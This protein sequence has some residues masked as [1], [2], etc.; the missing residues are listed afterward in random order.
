MTDMTFSELN[1]STSILQ[2]LD[3]MGFEAPSEIQAQCIPFLMSGRD[4]VGQAQT[5]TGKTAA[6]GIP[7]V[8]QVDPSVKEVQAVIM[9]PTR[10]LAIQV[11]G[12]LQKIGK[13]KKGLKAVP[14]YGG[15]PI[16]RQIKAIKRGAQIVVGTPG[17]T[18]DHLKRG[19]L[20]L[21]DLRMVVLD[22]ADEMLNMG[23]RDDIEEILSYA[24][25]ARQSIMFSATMSKAIR[26][27]MKRFMNN[28]ETVTIDRKKMTAPRIDQYVVEVR[29]S[30]RTEA[31]CRFMDI[32]D[33]RLALVFCNTKRQTEILARELKARGYSSD[34]INGDL[35]QRQR[36]KVMD[37]FRKQYI[38]ILVATDVAARGIDVDEVDAVFNYDIPQDPEYYVHRIGRT[39]RAGRSG[40]A[41]TFVS[42]R[43]NKYLRYVQ[44]QI[45]MRLDIIPMPSVQDVEESKMDGFMDEVL[46]TLEQGGLREY[47]EQVEAMSNGRF[48]GSEIAGAM[49]KMH[50]AET[51][52]DEQP[53][54][55][56]VST[57]NEPMQKLYFSVG[58]KNKIHPGDFVGAIAGETSVDGSV[59]GHI[60]IYPNH[61]FVDVPLST[62]DEIVRVM[63][64]VKVKGKNVKVRV[65]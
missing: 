54:D 9:C 29:D 15:Q 24:D 35:N 4:V 43:K 42:G 52:N 23:F 39:G 37:R 62:S 11:T 10:E 8:E 38:D 32:H 18:I 3:E 63:N 14:V 40:M 55:P 27:I 19:T 5:G 49:L 12:E 61:S 46:G 6:F 58:K 60:D 36:D 34:V 41:F 59:I 50:L 16:G 64:N 21:N 45:K 33:F 31:L 26:Q 2:G 30:V 65:A 7:V 48:T 1:L 44:K 57:A 20:R 13:Y 28:P 47:I 22:E 17:R 53:D 51:M 25:G 56:A